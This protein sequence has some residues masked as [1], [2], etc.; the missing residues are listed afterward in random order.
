MPRT[1]ERTAAA[2]APRR[3]DASEAEAKAL[4]SPLRLRIL[5]VCLGEPRT[6]KEI[7]QALAKDPATTLHHVR[8]LVDTGFLAALPGRRGMRGSRE[9]PYEATGKSWT[10]STPGA[11]GFMLE[12]F[13]EEVALVPAEAVDASRLGLRMEPAMYEEFTGRLQELFDEFAGRCD[14]A[15]SGDAWSVY[16]AIHPDPNRP[17][18]DRSA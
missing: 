13:L 7:A 1:P 14:R 11:S 10:L 5:R 3:R 4:A 6:N 18:R 17:P 8:T 16:F 15:G 12:T 9:I 2:D